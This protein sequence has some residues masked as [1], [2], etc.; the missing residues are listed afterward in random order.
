M[1]KQVMPLSGQYGK[2]VP[3]HN[4]VFD[5]SD[6]SAGLGADLA[7]ILQAVRGFL[8]DLDLHDIVWQITPEAYDL[9]RLEC[10]A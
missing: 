7:V 8:E 5:G 2:I 4:T 10:P 9:A 6:R 3:R 1:L